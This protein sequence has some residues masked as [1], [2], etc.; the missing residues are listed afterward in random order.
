MK[1]CRLILAGAMLAAL[2]TVSRLQA[3]DAG[4]GTAQAPA[5][6]QSMPAEAPK[7]PPE[8]V[9]GYLKLGFDRLGSYPFVPPTFDPT[10]DPKAVPP[11]GEEQIPAEVKSWNGRKVVVA[12][13]MMPLKMEKGLVTEFLLMKNTLMCCYGTAPN[14]N[15]LI[16]VKTSHGVHA[17]MDQPIS[18]YGELKVGATFDNGY[19]SGIYQLEDARMGEVVQN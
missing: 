10:V 18:F 19:L 8:V 12:G 7:T 15:E 11:T 13:F 5:V 1:F 2:P 4:A 16:L 6:L 9:D 17:S 3:A 14:L